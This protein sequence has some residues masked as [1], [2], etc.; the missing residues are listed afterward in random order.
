M[1]QKN[2]FDDPS[3]S[4]L[5]HFEKMEKYF[6]TGLTPH[7]TKE[8]FNNFNSPIVDFGEFEK[9]EYGTIKTVETKENF[10]QTPLTKK[11]NHLLNDSSYK[12]P[13]TTNLKEG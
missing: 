8:N 1:M 3:T 12:S 10:H 5:D 2:K 4:H 9:N 6:Q 7:S 13:E 11:I